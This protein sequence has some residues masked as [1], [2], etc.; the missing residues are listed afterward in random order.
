M[1][2]RGILLVP[3]HT[4]IRVYDFQFLRVYLTLDT[5]KTC[6]AKHFSV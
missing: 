4:Y 3:G 2:R 6:A 1:S 5:T